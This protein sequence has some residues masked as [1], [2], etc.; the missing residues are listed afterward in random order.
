MFRLI[1]EF[2]HYYTNLTW[3]APLFYHTPPLLWFHPSIDPLDIH[4]LQCSHVSECIGT[5]D[6]ITMTLFCLLIFWSIFL[7]FSPFFLEITFCRF[8]ASNTNFKY[9]N[10]NT[11]ACGLR[12]LDVKG[13]HEIQD[14]RSSPCGSLHLLEARVLPS[15]SQQPSYTHNCPL[16]I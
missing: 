2:F 16:P 8:K 5:H 14:G 12:M 11:R 10:S 1:G 9:G 13:T 15:Q 6:A 3:I 7:L 4:I